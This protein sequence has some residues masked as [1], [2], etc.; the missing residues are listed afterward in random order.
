[1]ELRDLEQ[2]G[3]C[4]LAQGGGVSFALAALWAA[5]TVMWLVLWVINREITDV[6]MATASLGVFLIFSHEEIHHG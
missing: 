2:R 6:A 1:M 5:L 3:L 4:A